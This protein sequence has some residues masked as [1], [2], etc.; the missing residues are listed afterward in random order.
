MYLLVYVPLFCSSQDL[1]KK[2][3]NFKSGSDVLFFVFLIVKGG[4]KV[5][6]PT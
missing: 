2:V 6:S 1:Q 4:R 5:Y 3:R